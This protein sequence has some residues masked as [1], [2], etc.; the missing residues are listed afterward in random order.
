M[1]FVRDLAPAEKLELYKKIKGICLFEGYNFI[2]TMKD[3]L[4]NKVKDVLPIV[5]YEM[6]FSPME[7]YKDYSYGRY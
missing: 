5:D 6:G 7:V 2:D 1:M 4:D 3:T